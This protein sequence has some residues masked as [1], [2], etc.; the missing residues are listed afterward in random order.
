MEDAAAGVF[1]FFVELTM[2]SDLDVLFVGV[3]WATQVHQVAVVDGA[4]KL[5]GERAVEHTAAGLAQFS[6]WLLGFGLPPG[7]IRVAIEVPHGAV[8][9]SLV[10]RAFAVFSINPKQLD[11]FR[12]RFS[13]SGAKDDRRDAFVLADSL[14]TDVQCFRRVE[15]DPPRIIEIREWSRVSDDLIQDRIRLTNRLRE[16]LLR[17]YPQFLDLADDV[18]ADW[19]LELWNKLP[20]PAHAARK[21]RASV[22]AILK[23]HRIRRLDSDGVLAK[24]RV[25]PLTVAPGTEAAAMAHIAVLVDLLRVVND[26]LRTTRKQLRRR[27]EEM[28]KAVETDEGQQVEQRDVSIVLS[29]PGVGPIVCATLLGE[30]GRLLRERNY[31]AL[32]AFCGVAPVTRRSGK[33]RPLV[34]MRHGCNQRLRNA[35]YHWARVACQH[36]AICKARYASLRSRGH[37]HGRALRSVADRLLYVLIA[38]LRNQTTYRA[39][40]AA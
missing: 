35:A 13:M 38:M 29:M 2:P 9:E 28:S 6:A 21:C 12:D 27:I 8:V 19:L 37:S 23:R 11:R 31:P 26:K 17:Y 16:Q 20:A 1:T 14:R 33:A 40:C 5:L 22:A 36:D 7:S 39:P 32:R 15:L 4:G 25:P 3:D 18:G 24:L 34:L 10:E 30:A